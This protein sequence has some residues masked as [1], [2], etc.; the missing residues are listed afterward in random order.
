M[1]SS[2][3]YYGTTGADNVIIGHAAAGDNTGNHNSLTASVY[4]GHL[5]GYLSAGNNVVAIGKQAAYRNY[6]GNSVAIGNYSGGYYQSSSSGD[7]NVSIGHEA[8]YNKQSASDN[9]SIGSKAA[10][11]LTSGN[12]NVFIGREAGYH[13]TATTGGHNNVI[14]GAYSNTS[15]ASSDTEV[16]V[17]YNVTGRGN[18][19]FTT[20]KAGSWVGLSF[21]STTVSSSSDERL[22]ENIQNSTAGLSFINDLRPVTFEW[23]KAKDI[24]ETFK[25]YDADSEE[26]VMSGDGVYH[27]FIA[28]EVKT[29][30]DNHDELKDGFDMWSETTDGTQAVGANALIPMLVKSIQELSTE[31]TALKAEIK[32]LK[33]E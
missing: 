25:D 13:G 1:G 8:C 2:A 28:Q 27:G 10:F 29:V 3:F 21:G 33:G 22:K 24:P 6:G 30:I 16:V 14:I 18:N 7:N 19:T 32:A 9:V 12:A 26:R 31:V 15:Q 20:G 5:A 17:G 4:I 11:S 23:K